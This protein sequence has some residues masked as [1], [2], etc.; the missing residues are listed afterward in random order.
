MNF[1]KIAAAS[2]GRLCCDT[3]PRTRPNPSSDRERRRRAKARRRRA[4]HRLLHRARQPGD[5]AAGY[6]G[7]CRARPR[8]R[9][10]A[11][12][13]RPE[14]DRL[15]EAKTRRHR[16]G[17]VRPHRKIWGFDLVV[18]PAQVRDPRRRVR[19]NPGRGR[20]HLARDRSRGRSPPCAT[21][22]ASWAGRAK[23]TAARTVRTQGRSG[24][25]AFRHHTARPTLTSRTGRRRPDLP[26]T[27]RCRP[28]RTRTSTTSC[29]TW[30]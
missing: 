14:I 12:A 7:I 21:S 18:Q 29:S 9:S 11:H 30:W 16:R 24:G 1:R 15:F 26:S 5:L 27:C 4:P 28:T 23:A 3:S 8:G 13:E 19:A 25:S 2:K 6:A 22:P 17:L 20:R 10:H